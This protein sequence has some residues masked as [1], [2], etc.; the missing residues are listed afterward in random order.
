M[1]LRLRRSL[2]EGSEI[3][4]NAICRT[5][6]NVTGSCCAGCAVCPTRG[7]WCGR[8]SRTPPGTPESLRR[9][10]RNRS[11]RRERRGKRNRRA[12]FNLKEMNLCPI[13]GVSFASLFWKTVC[14]NRYLSWTREQNY[15]SQR[16]QLRPRRPARRL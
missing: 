16:R 5:S 10:R 7:R 13:K 12:Y 11:R 9:R 1:D 4:P 6:E 14:S 8:S 2:K 3:D 15:F